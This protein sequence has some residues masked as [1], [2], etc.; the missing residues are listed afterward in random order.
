MRE[1]NFWYKKPR[2]SE[3]RVITR[4]VIARYD[5]I[6][7]V[8]FDKRFVLFIVIVLNLIFEFVKVNYDEIT[9]TLP[10]PLFQMHQT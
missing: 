10:N 6:T 5:C 4:R 3:V 7:F 8:K 9:A 2:Y 1:E